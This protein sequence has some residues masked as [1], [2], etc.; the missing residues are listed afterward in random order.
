MHRKKEGR[1]EGRKEGKKERK[2][3]RKRG[4]PSFNQLKHSDKFQSFY[5]AFR[6][7]CFDGPTLHLCFFDP[8]FGRAGELLDGCPHK[9]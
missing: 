5:S 4:V 3:E 8:P 7:P 1:K 6:S 9:I 2:K